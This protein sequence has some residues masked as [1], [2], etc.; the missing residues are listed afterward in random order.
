MSKTVPMWH[1]PDELLIPVELTHAGKS[2]EFYALWDTGTG[3]GIIT[4]DI[5]L[6]LRAPG[7]WHGLRALYSKTEE[8]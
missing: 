5:A 4:Q 7:L 8:R 2:L 1:T 3:P 6:G